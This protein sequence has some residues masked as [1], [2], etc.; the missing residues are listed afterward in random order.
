MVEDEPVPQRFLWTLLLT[1]PCFCQDVRPPAECGREIL[2][3]AM[4]DRN[5]DTRK[6]AATALG[7]GGPRQPFLSELKAMLDDKDVEV[8]VAAITSLADW[9]SKEALPVLRKGLDDAVPEVSFAAAKALYAL[10]DPAGKTA[11]LAILSG[12]SKVAS[13]FLSKQRR[14]ALRMLH[15]PKTTIM[16]GVRQGLGFVPVPGLGE[17][18]AS[19]QGLL[20]DPGVSGRAMTAL[21][22][23][24]E[25]DP[26]TMFALREALS[27][28]D[29]SV[30]AAAIH[31]L[32]LRN[33]P[34]VVPDLVPL[35]DDKHQGV[36]L[37]AAAACLRLEEIRKRARPGAAGKP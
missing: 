6:L 11:L 12:E 14:D 29:W 37:R 9:K 7:L 21:L 5:P 1:I 8:R 15:T 4:T 19:L 30:R 16:L 20:S 26:D 10:H 2:Q 34:A 31:S 28:K 22:L 17:G 36:R 27:D 35:L 3:S 18:M 33:D 23:G 13:G 25:K 32:A 24:K